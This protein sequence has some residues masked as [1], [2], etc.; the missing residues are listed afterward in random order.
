MSPLSTGLKSF[1]AE[2][3]RRRVF[4][5]AAIYLVVAWV[6]IQI[7]EATFPSLALPEWALRLVI[8]MVALGFPIALVLAWAYDL[9]PAGD[10]KIV[11]TPDR[12]DSGSAADSAGS[13]RTSA[14]DAVAEASAEDGRDGDGRTADGRDGDGPDGDGREGIESIAVLPFADMSPEGDQEYFGDGLAEELLNLL[15]SCCRHLHVP[16]RTSCFAF[17]GQNTDVR[18]IGKTLGVDAVLEGSVRKDGDRLRITAQLVD[19]R[20]GYHLWSERFDRT[21]HDVFAIQDEIARRVVDEL[22]LSLA[23][24]EQ[25]SVSRAPS[26]DVRAYEYYLRGRQLFHQITRRSIDAA[27]GMF[28]HAIQLDPKYARAHAGLADCYSYIFSFWDHRP[29]VLAHADAASHTA[30]E[31]D[32]N[33]AEAHVARGEALNL[34]GRPAE[35]AHQF[36]RAIELNPSLFE[37]F[38]F[39]ARSCFAHGQFEKAIELFQDAH[40][41]R[42][43]DYQSVVLLGIV[44][45]EVGQMKQ[46]DEADRK[47]IEVIEEHLRLNPDDARAYYMG[48]SCWASVYRPDKAREWIQQA[49]SLDPDD[50]VVR[51]GV[52]CN[53]ARLGDVEE[54]LDNLERAVELGFGY[55]EWI[56]NDSDWLAVR[57]HPRF[58]SVLA[59]LAERQKA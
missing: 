24:Y 22:D 43:E 10:Q 55:R 58:L 47:A 49:L 15:T 14:A 46:A 31:L 7:G 35:A 48:A 41:V 6:I 25:A 21:L 18:E 4:R 33:L 20:N 16:A 29:E 8:V 40:R 37:A 36:E 51:Y 27:R 39:Y 30:L 38:Y 52:G 28:E 53:Y 42:P 9:T 50:A 12:A 3:R 34:M 5:A 59:S 32:P 57:D 44:L 11:R 2:L 23:D 13:R 54:A 19:V 45:R 17:K 1:A 56:A 26:V